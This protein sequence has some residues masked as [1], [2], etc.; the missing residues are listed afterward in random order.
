MDTARIIAA[1][2]FVIILVVLIIRLKGRA[3]T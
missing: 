3:K 2:A 1:V